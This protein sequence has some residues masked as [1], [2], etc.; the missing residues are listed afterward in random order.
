[1]FSRFV[2]RSPVGVLVFGT[3]AAEH[4]MAM[5]GASSQTIVVSDRP[6]ALRG[7][8]V[9]V[10]D[11]TTQADPLAALA[12]VAKAP[13]ASVVAVVDAGSPELDAELRE[14]GADAVVGS[15]EGALLYAM[16]CGLAVRLH[17]G[18]VQS[19]TSARLQLS[20]V[21]PGSAADTSALQAVSEAL[22]VASDQLSAVVRA[23]H[24]VLQAA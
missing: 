1:M 18:L 16:A 4:W 9:L 11:L 23:L 8:A 17:D 20:M 15:A 6:E 13:S 5:S 7:C 22:D 2:A 12:A 21:A 14:A 19:L 3:A 24:A 10:V